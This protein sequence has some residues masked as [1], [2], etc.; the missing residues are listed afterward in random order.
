MI[1]LTMVLVLAIGI[2]LVIDVLSFLQYDTANGVS[3]K[4]PNPFILKQT[5]VKPHLQNQYTNNSIVNKNS[6]NDTN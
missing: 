3:T 1:F 4:Y 2:L 5:V 6:N